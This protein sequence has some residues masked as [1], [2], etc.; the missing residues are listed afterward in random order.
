MIQGLKSVGPSTEDALRAFEV[1]A[2]LSLPSDYRAW[3]LQIGAGTLGHFRILCPLTGGTSLGDPRVHWG[4]LMDKITSTSVVHVVA[5]SFPLRDLVPFAQD[6]HEDVWLAWERG[7]LAR[8]DSSVLFW[9]EQPRSPPPRRL[10][11]SFQEVACEWALTSRTQLLL[12]GVSRFQEK[13]SPQ[14]D[15][16]FED[17]WS[18]DEERIEA[19][20]VGTAVADLGRKRSDTAAV[21]E[22]EVPRTFRPFPRR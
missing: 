15:K 3:A 17:N 20:V 4:R 22:L 7:R 12:L 13:V 14:G 2:R 21:D 19:V 11:G 8:G 1:E 10:A 18:D 16:D 5:H 6:V 9:D